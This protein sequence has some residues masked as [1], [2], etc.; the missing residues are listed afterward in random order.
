MYVCIISQCT[1]NIMFSIL[2]LW[3]CYD[4]RFFISL[5]VEM[6]GRDTVDLHL[7][8]I[9]RAITLCEQGKFEQLFSLYDLK[10][11]IHGYHPSDYLTKSSR[12][13]IET[14]A[15][16]NEAKKELISMRR[17]SDKY[18]VLRR[19]PAFVGYQSIQY[20][21]AQGNVVAVRKLI[22]VYRCSQN[23]SYTQGKFCETPLCL[24]CY[25]GHLDVVKCLVKE[26]N[27]YFNKKHQEKVFD[28]LCWEREQRFNQ[29][30]FH[31]QEQCV[32]KNPIK[33]DGKMGDNHIEIIIFLLDY[34]SLN[35]TLFKFIVLPED[36]NMTLFLKCFSIFNLSKTFS[37]LQNYHFINKN[38]EIIKFLI[39]IKEIIPNSQVIAHAIQTNS[40]EEVISMLVSVCETNPIFEPVNEGN[41]NLTERL[42]YYVRNPFLLKLLLEKFG[43][44]QNSAN[45]Q[46]ILHYI[47]NSTYP[48]IELV[49]YV[50]DTKPQLQRMPDSNLQLPLH[51]VCNKIAAHYVGNYVLE[52]IDAVS[53]D[54]DINA[55]DKDGN[56]P[57]H[58]ACQ[59]DQY[60]GNRQVVEYLI[61][62]KKA[63]ITHRNSNGMIPMHYLYKKR[64]L[65][66][67][68][69]TDKVDEDGNTLL[70]IA[71]MLGDLKFVRELVQAKSALVERSNSG[72]QLPLHLIVYRSNLKTGETNEMIDLLSNDQTVHVQDNEGNT[73]MHS[74]CIHSKSNPAQL[75]CFIRRIPSTSHVLCNEDGKQPIHIILEYHDK[76]LLELL[77]KEVDFNSPNKCGDT[78]LHLACKYRCR[79]DIITYLVQTRGAKATGLNIE[80]YSPIHLTFY[81]GGRLSLETYRILF[82]ETDVDVDLQDKDGNTALHLACDTCN[83]QL[84]TFLVKSKG[85]AIYIQN[86]KGELP[87]HLILKGKRNLD[88]INLLVNCTTLFTQDNKGNT[89]LHNSCSFLLHPIIFWLPLSSKENTSTYSNSIFLS[90]VRQV[91]M[92]LKNKKNLTAFQILIDRKIPHIVLELIS[93]FSLNQP[94]HRTL[95]NG[96]ALHALFQQSQCH[97]MTLCDGFNLHTQCKLSCHEM[98]ELYNVKV[99]K[100]LLTPTNARVKNSNG[101]L[102][103]HTIFDT[104]IKN[105]FQFAVLYNLIPNKEEFINAQDDNGDTPLHIAVKYYGNNAVDFLYKQG[106]CDLSLKNTCGEI[107]LHR[108]VQAGAHIV[109][110]LQ[111]MT[112]DH[113]SA[114]NNDGLT[115]IHLAVRSRAL[116]IIKY[117]HQNFEDA[118][119]LKS[120]KGDFPFRFLFNR[121][122]EYDLSCG[123]GRKYYKPT[124]ELQMLEY[125]VV[126]G[127]CLNY[128]ERNFLARLSC[129]IG[130]IETNKYLKKR[131][132]LLACNRS[133][134][135][136]PYCDI[137]RVTLLT[138]AASR[139]R[140]D[141]LH[142]LIEEEQIHPCSTDEMGRNAL[143]YACG[144][145]K[146]SCIFC[147]S[148]KFPSEDSIQLLIQSGCSI[149]E[150]IGN[151]QEYENICL[152]DYVC[153]LHDLQLL[154]FL[155]SSNEIVDRSRNTPLIKVLKLAEKSNLHDFVI[156]A[157]KL[158]LDNPACNQNLTNYLGESALCLAC[159]FDFLLDV[160]KKFNLPIL[161]NHLYNKAIEMAIRYNNT[162]IFEYLF[163][164]KQFQFSD[165]QKLCFLKITQDD[166][167]VMIM[168]SMSFKLLLDH[169]Q[170]LSASTIKLYLDRTVRDDVNHD[171]FQGLNNT[172]LHIACKYNNLLIVKRLLKDDVLN[173]K[174]EN[175]NTPLHLAC[176]YNRFKIA[177]EILLNRH[178]ADVTEINDNGDTPLHVACEYASGKIIELFGE[179]SCNIKNNSGNTPLH[180]AC[181]KESY[182]SVRI[183]NSRCSLKVQNLAG[184]TPLHIAC[185]LGSF[186]ILYYLLDH[187]QDV[188]DAL[189]IQNQDGNLPLHIGLKKFGKRSKITFICLKSLFNLCKLTPIRDQNEVLELLCQDRIPQSHKIAEH[190]RSK[191][192][193]IDT[194]IEFGNLPIHYASSKNLAL[195]K[196]YASADVINSQNSNGDTA[197]H[198]ACSHGKY[199]ISR[200]LIEN[201][202]CDV[203]IRNKRG[204]LALHKA[205]NATSPKV[206]IC[207]LLFQCSNFIADHSGNYPI[208][209]LCMRFTGTKLTILLEMMKV[210]G[211][212]DSIAHPNDCNELPIHHLCKSKT[213]YTYHAVEVLLQYIS[214]LNVT[215]LSGETPLHLAC[216]SEQHDIIQLLANKPNCD[217]SMPNSR[218]DLALHLV[219]GPIKFSESPK[220]FEREDLIGKAVEE[221]LAKSSS[222]F[223]TIKILANETTINATNIDGDTPLHLA[224]QNTSLYYH[225]NSGIYG[226]KVYC[227]ILDTVI[228][229]GASLEQSNSKGQF[230]IHL[231]CQ[232]PYAIPVMELVGYYG[233]S[234]TTTESDNIFHLA[235][236]SYF[237]T[238]EVIE[239]LAKKVGNADLLHE[240]NSSDQFPLHTFCKYASFNKEILLY[241]LDHCDN[242][243][244]QDKDKNTPLHLLL[245]KDYIF[246]GIETIEVLFQLEDCDLTLPNS[247]GEMALDLIVNSRLVESVVKYF[248]NGSKFKKIMS[249]AS[250]KFL[251]SLFLPRQNFDIIKIIT[252]H[253]IDPA[254][255]YKAHREFFNDERKAPQVPV[256]MLFIGDAM[257]GKTTLVNSLRR[258]AGLTV[259]QGEPERTAG[260]IPSN[261]QSSKYGAVTAYDFA[262]QREYYAT[263]E[264]VM[265]SIMQ[266]T[267]PIVLIQVKLCDAEQK[268][269][270]PRKDIIKKI[271]YWCR[272]IKNR[273]KCVSKPHLVIVFS[274]ADLVPSVND[275]EIDTTFTSYIIKTH[276]EF[277][278]ACVLCMDCR[279][280]QGEGVNRLVS[281]LMRST[282]ILRHKGVTSFRAHCLLVFLSQHLKDEVFITLEGLFNFKE[283]MSHKEETRPLL[284][285]DFEELIELCEELE[286][287]GQIMI[288]HNNIPR[289]RTIILD[290]DILLNEITG[291]LFAP[292]EFLIHEDISSN[293]GVVTFSKVKSLFPQYDP[294]AVLSFLC[295]IEY[296][297]EI[298][299]DIVLSL[300]FEIPETHG[301]NDRYFFFPGLIKVKRPVL[302]FEK[303]KTCKFCWALKCK[304]NNYFSNY[305]IQILLLRFVFEFTKVSFQSHNQMLESISKVWTSGLFWFNSKG[306]D[307]FV[308]VVDTS[309]LILFMQCE[310]KYRLQLFKHRSILVTQIRRLHTE[311][312]NSIE[313]EEYLVHVKSFEEIVNNKYHLIPLIEFIKVIR[314]NAHF[315]PTRHGN[316]AV[317]EIIIFDPYMCLCQGLV[318]SILNGKEK[319]IISP[320]FIK[321]L[322][323]HISESK[324][325]LFKELCDQLCWRDSK[326]KSMEDNAKL[327]IKEIVGTYQQLQRELNS[328]SILGNVF[329]SGV[330]IC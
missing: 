168:K 171:S 128:N 141:I 324:F 240:R 32:R 88:T 267:P 89:P 79:E 90:S 165:E 92:K 325:D 17:D 151:S 36:F 130:F 11:R 260:V 201:M 205:C 256:S 5:L 56:T 203:S 296:C 139:G 108:A 50:S 68:D 234:Q 304:E 161:S 274:H 123:S 28:L 43:D 162:E 152:F 122:H 135:Q 220:Y 291:K 309:E 75:K 241:M 39:K 259:S 293:T 52:L 94:C 273:L 27:C 299:H 72:G 297:S 70:H 246:T 78:P 185:Q 134:R 42:A 105:L 308:D 311:L 117:F 242:I 285:F 217:I 252:R 144:F 225:G 213:Q 109:K 177:K 146:C 129:N 124:D 243:N 284:S 211:A 133:L 283:T 245:M 207:K 113:V 119:S 84:I 306:I 131:T 175:G 46:N 21:A 149:Y 251:L 15:A 30:Y 268:S 61:E 163:T 37:N 278:V 218:K 86:N 80:G 190:F 322:T 236:Q 73:P 239:H 35:T 49:N 244:F 208:H 197:L 3:R 6:D 159:R 157:A 53:S 216:L 167:A 20:A 7:P 315:I 209:F 34:S 250:E 305:F 316:I 4:Y 58:I 172:P 25:Y 287:N 60:Y 74:A 254:P 232:H 69:H 191:G 31:M 261:F 59:I 189:S 132:K 1:Y 8:T 83:E 300:I 100:A 166:M 142:Y 22:Q 265:E 204:E 303:E 67:H 143:V 215:T 182:I 222:I 102:L 71:C 272:F 99:I 281:V 173:Q 237:V 227:K 289:K 183:L 206:N 97:G 290:K 184:D 82:K 298:R 154:K 155:T 231:A 224:L 64:L 158:L 57:L 45:N 103:I 258:E 62:K 106:I 181:L 170:E 253:G 81:M 223:T 266:K 282:S 145:F 12:E 54:C 24:A 221:L 16:N 249:L 188:K 160:I 330:F 230:P 19:L 126:D 196:V 199:S 95:C 276:T 137:D 121:I 112:F 174:N 317:R 107:P 66:P 187:F 120:G 270:I 186:S 14:I 127:V 33:L 115:P 320:K 286:S 87:L 41:R 38:I 255:L 156:D 198:I 169:E 314:E 302:D 10:L 295:T 219:C 279:D 77:P 200:Y 193:R 125:C 65:T 248:S 194:P 93:L 310:P 328:I 179:Q 313:C 51:L 13:F 226:L 280:F 294:H 275:S 277:E 176:R 288:L 212:I 238:L 18:S 257:T 148:T 104:K 202:E 307:T 147:T 91:Y 319:K 47:C 110:Q 101:Q 327:W 29:L 195:V 228:S 269:I 301:R 85:A 138:T 2:S 178:G 140:T 48:K 44:T 312:C 271:D 40:S 264:A 263:H 214:D 136:H 116:N 180:L 9:P 326:V 233:I 55:R 111:P 164:Y 150:S 329:Q 321:C 153:R 229:L 323:H 235:C 114:L 192:L 318:N 210:P 76:S 247:N 96:L 292:S 26:S 118:F 23:Y 63:V 262:G 98:N